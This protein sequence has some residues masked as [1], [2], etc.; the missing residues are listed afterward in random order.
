MYKEKGDN[1]TNVHFI[2][3]YVWNVLDGEKSTGRRRYSPGDRVK[4]Q[5]QKQYT[6]TER[7]TTLKVS[8]HCMGKVSCM[9]LKINA[10]SLPAIQSEI[11]NI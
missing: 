4:N 10:S 8:L 5:N 6:T 11:S 1:K 2:Q 7:R 9:K 3:K